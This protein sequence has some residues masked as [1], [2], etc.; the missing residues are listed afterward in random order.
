MIVQEKKILVTRIQRFSLHDGPGIRTTIFLKGCSVRCPWCCNPENLSNTPQSYIKDGVKDVYG[1]YYGANGLYE[2]IMKDET[3][4]MDSPVDYDICHSSDISSLP[5]GITFSGGEPLLQMEQLRPLLYLL[6]QR[7]IHMAA[8]T[9]LFA[10]Q[11]DLCLAAKYI[12]LFYVDFKILDQELCEKYIGGDL[13][14]FFRNLYSLAE[15]RKPIIVRIPVI[16]GY[17]EDSRNRKKTADLICDLLA[18]GN[19]LKVELLKE[20]NLGLDKYQSLIACDTGYS[21]PK[22]IG[23]SDSVMKLYREELIDRIENR[24]PVEICSV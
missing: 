7:H 9:S 1:I 24:I 8:E 17:T 11:K 18:R 13:E 3:F 23:V 2:E 20:H 22:Y 16:G 4:F 5:G 12:N 10:P 6:G 15:A 19:I 21:L 14:L